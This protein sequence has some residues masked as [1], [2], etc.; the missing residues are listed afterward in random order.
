LHKSSK[1]KIYSAEFS[2][3][4]EDKELVNTE[5]KNEIYNRKDCTNL[6]CY[7]WPK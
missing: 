4:P 1:F 5:F 6:R 3:Y 7:R 2:N